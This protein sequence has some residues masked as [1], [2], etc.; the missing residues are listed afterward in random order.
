MKDERAATRPPGD[1][2]LAD[3]L[4]L[5]HMECIGKARL[6]IIDDDE[7]TCRV[8]HDAL[9]HPDF[10]IRTVN[11]VAHIEETIRRQESLHLVILDFVLPGVQTEVVLAW[12]HQLH[13][14]AEV[15]V[16]TGYP[17]V[18][19]A[20]TA[21]RARVFDYITKPFQL[22]HLRRT[23]IKCL[24]ARGVLRMTVEALRLAVGAA[25][26]ERRKTLD[27]TLAEMVRRTGISLGYLSQIEL[28]K[29]SASIETL[30]KISLALGVRLH[31]LFQSLQR[32]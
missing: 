23:V 28:G 16:I 7:M 19:G 2:S 12:I 8:I 25:I 14:A 4:T 29:N 11:Q 9:A 27:L 13:P 26:R 20:Q 17:T 1:G 15:I 21:L 5:E 18:E 3:T 24:E 22:A 30:Y 32:P 6:L 31:E 10:D